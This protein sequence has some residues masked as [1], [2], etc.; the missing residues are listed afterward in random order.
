MRV[1]T[2]FEANE[3]AKFTFCSLHRSL[4]RVDIGPTNFVGLLHLDRI[5]NIREIHFDV[6]FYAH[7]WHCAHGLDAAVD[8]EIADM[9]LVWNS[10][11]L[12]NCPV[13]K[14]QVWISA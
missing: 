2:E 8:S 1:A 11:E 13:V 14:L 12:V 3:I 4:E 6:F 10:T 7:F 9:H 5:P